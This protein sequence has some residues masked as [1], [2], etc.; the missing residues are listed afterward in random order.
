MRLCVFASW[1]DDLFQL[2][3]I[4]KKNI[5]AASIPTKILGVYTIWR[6]GRWIPTSTYLLGQGAKNPKLIIFA[7]I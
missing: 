3:L 5:R 1:W 4:F 6:K 2:N 7:T